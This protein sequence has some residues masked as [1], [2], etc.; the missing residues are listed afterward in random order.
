LF[1]FTQNFEVTDIAV[2]QNTDNQE[3]AFIQ[4]RMRNFKIISKAI[5][6][7][8]YFNFIN[9]NVKIKRSTKGRKNSR[10]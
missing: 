1:L 10:K 2:L 7:E 3:R 8:I 5:A 6:L 4:K 9:H